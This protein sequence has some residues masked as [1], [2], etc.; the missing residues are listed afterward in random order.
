MFTPCVLDFYVMFPFHLPNHGHSTA[1]AHVHFPLEG[2]VGAAAR[3]GSI[4][5]STAPLQDPH[6]SPTIDRLLTAAAP[7][8]RLLQFF[9]SSDFD[10]TESFSF[11]WDDVLS[12]RRVRIPSST[13]FT[14]NPSSSLTSDVALAFQDE[15]SADLEIGLLPL[16]TSCTRWCYSSGTYFNIEHVFISASNCII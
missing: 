3:A 8:E 14:T 16:E 10:A 15:Y 13:V 2:V 9:A 11:N 1:P 5:A 12:A 4:V 6:Y 7:A